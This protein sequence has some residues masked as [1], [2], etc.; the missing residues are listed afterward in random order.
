V[1]FEEAWEAREERAL[2]DIAV[3]LICRKHL[4]RNKRRVGRPQDK[5][6]ARN[7]ASRR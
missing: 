1:E 7:L 2:D 4:I 5:I 3:H 6:D